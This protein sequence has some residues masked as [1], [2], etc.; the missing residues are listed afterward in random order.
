MFKQLPLAKTFDVNSA[1]NLHLAKFSSM[2]LPSRLARFVGRSLGAVLV[3]L[4]L[5]SLAHAEIF[6]C[7]LGNGVVEYNNTVTAGKDKNCKKIDLPQ[8]TTIP[9]PKIPA[10]Q[11]GAGRPASSATQTAAKSSPS[12]FPKVDASTQKARDTDRRRII[13]D[14][15]KKEEGKLSEL[16][17]DYNGGEPERQGDERNFQKYLDRVQKMKEDIARGESNVAALRKELGSVKE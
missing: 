17:K 1:A 5:L 10:A 6:R 14:E 3:T 2:A 11:A 15:L 13:E 12:D 9:A 16:K 4:S 7:E 8:I